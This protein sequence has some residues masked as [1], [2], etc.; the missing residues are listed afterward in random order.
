MGRL[1]T[2][3]SKGQVT[4]PKEVRD[5]VGIKPHDRIDFVVEDGYATLKRFPTLDELAGSFPSLAPLGLDI[6]VEEA[7]RLAKEERAGEIIDT[8]HRE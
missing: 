1:T 5:A 2:V 4:I 6:S 7:I 3:T 8:M